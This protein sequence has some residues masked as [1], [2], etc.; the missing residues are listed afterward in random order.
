MLHRVVC[1]IMQVHSASSCSETRRK[2]VDGGNLKGIRIIH[3]E[4]RSLAAVLHGML[5]LV[6]GIRNRGM[7]PDF[8][9]LGAMVY[10]IDAFPERYHH[11]KEDRYLFTLLRRGAP[12]LT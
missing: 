9:V 5:Y 11:P 4:H 1:S 2:R 12:L 3:D 6:N 8:K 7:K 10:Y